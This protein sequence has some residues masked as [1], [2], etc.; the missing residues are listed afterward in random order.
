MNWVSNMDYS[1]DLHIHSALSPCASRDMTPNN[2]VNMAYIKKLDIISIT[3]HNTMENIE[4]IMK[5]GED[6]NILVIPGIEVTTKEEVHVLCFFEDVKDGLK[7]SRRIYDSLPYIKNKEKFFEEQ[8]ILDVKDEI[9]GKLDKLLISRCS[10]TIDEVN[11]FASLNNGVMVPAHV[12]RMSYSIISTLG[13]IPEE[14]QI[15]T[16]EISSQGDLRKMQKFIDLSR[17]KKIVNSDAH[18]L[19]NI[20]EAEN[21]IEIDKLT[22]EEVIKYLKEKKR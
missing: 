10:Y 13:F 21:F 19:Y 3:D 8:L 7:F 1:I 14:L 9:V 4:S 15:A 11:K 18:D 6:K 5:L 20:S 12:N 2:I 16:I 17:Y 22:R